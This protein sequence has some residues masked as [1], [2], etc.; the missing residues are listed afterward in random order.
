MGRQP[1]VVAPNPDGLLEL[2]LMTRDAGSPAVSSAMVVTTLVG[3]A[4]LYGILLVVELFLLRRYVMAGP[5]GV[6][7]HAP[8]PDPEPDGDGDGDDAPPTDDQPT[9]DEEADVLAFAY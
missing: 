1:W 8:Q 6:M 3:F 2:R 7:P 9:R 4:L 5:E